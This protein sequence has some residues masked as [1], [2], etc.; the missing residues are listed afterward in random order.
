MSQFTDAAYVRRHGTCAL[1]QLG[2]TLL[3]W[4]TTAVRLF[5][6]LACHPSSSHNR[7]CVSRTSNRGKVTG[8]SENGETHDLLINKQPLSRSGCCWDFL[9]VKRLFN[10]IKIGIVRADDHTDLH[11]IGAQSQWYVPKKPKAGSLVANER[12]VSQPLTCAASVFQF[13]LK[14]AMNNG[15]QF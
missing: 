15:I 4:T 14:G 12:T 10:L 1:V 6:K 3:V 13:I 8:C 2:Q 9:I 7:C 11:I 5:T